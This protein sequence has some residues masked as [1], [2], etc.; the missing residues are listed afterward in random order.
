MLAAAFLAAAA[1]AAVADPGWQ[2]LEPLYRDLH[3]HPELSFQE[4]ATASKLAERLRALG[5]EVTAGVGRTGVVGLLR[6]GEGPT[7]M[8]RT[9]MDA[10]PV[11]E[12]TGLPFASVATAQNA[13]GETVSVMHACG[14]DLHMTVWVG[15]ATRLARERGR[16]HGTLMMVAQPAE[17]VGGGARAMLDDGL[18]SRFP[19]PDVALAVHDQDILPSGVIGIRG[20]PVLASSDS[21]DV[22]VFGRGGHGARPQATVDPIAIAAKFVVS[23]QT[24]VSRENDPFQPAVVTVGS[25]HGGTKHNII[26]EEVRLQLTVRAFDEGVRRHLLEGIERIAKAEAE[27][28]LAPRAPEI[29]LSDGTPVTTNDAAL[30]G[31]IRPALE[32][33]L[34]ADRVVDAVPVMPAEDFSLYGREGVPILM[35]WLGAV[36]PSALARSR[37]NGTAVPG[38]HSPQWTP[39]AAKAAPVGIDALVAASLAVFGRGD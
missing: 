17:E 18:F 22:T 33:A 6:N 8:L 3:A 21:V 36:E 12:R 39:D 31:R 2:D 28:A 4:T 35:L 25:I 10:L 15:A 24:L 29:R 34:G 5:F 1:A 32:R 11:A 37:A 20:G 38:L 26:P 13:A 27:A 23:L 19:R 30:A 14:H 9:E 16:W 7:V